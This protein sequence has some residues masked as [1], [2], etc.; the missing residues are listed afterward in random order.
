MNKKG[1]LFIEAAIVLPLFL[2]ALLSISILIRVVATEEITMNSFGLEG[3]TFAKEIYLMELDSIPENYGLAEGIHGAIIEQRVKERISSGDTVKLGNIHISKDLISLLQEDDKSIVKFNLEYDMDVPLPL[4]F[5]RRLE[6]KQS[7]LFR[8]FVGAINEGEGMGFDAMEKPDSL[9]SVY[10]F[11]RAGEK[12][13]V[14]DCRIIEVYP[15]E[16]LLSASLKK[17]YDPCKLCEAKSLPWGAKVY[18]FGKS[19]KV[20]HKGSCATVD[21]Y[22]IE[23]DRDEALE[24]GYTPC[25]FCGGGN[26]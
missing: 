12:F 2:L 13:H 17:D 22:V 20:Y 24:K 4:A 23:M 3:Q 9:S 5:K 6:I 8:G 21:R 10:V 14:F 25:A 15:I 7:L 11:P 1:S 18:C 19:G 26:E 16:K